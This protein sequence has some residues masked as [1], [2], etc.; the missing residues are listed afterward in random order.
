MKKNILFFTEASTKIGYGHLSRCLSL[1]D[2]LKS[3]YKIFF[4]SEENI[5]RFLPKSIKMIN[6]DNHKNFSFKTVI[7]DL[8]NL[9]KNNFDKIKKFKI[10]NKIIISDHINSKLKSSLTIIPYL[11]IIKA[12]R[13]QKVIN[14]LDALI[15][16]K[17]LISLAKKKGSITKKLHYVIITICFGGSDPKNYTYKIVN[18]IIKLNL[19]LNIKF[20]I[21]IGSL[22]NKESEKKLKDLTYNFKNFEIYRNPKNLYK[23]FNQSNLALINSG[24]I[25]YE[26]A[27]LGVPFFLFAND[28]KS[29]VF[30]RIFKNYFKFF[31]YKDFNFPKK[32]YLK[33][34]LCNLSRKEKKLN[35][36]AKFNKKRINLNSIH[37]VVKHINN[38]II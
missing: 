10:K 38:T 7:I 27:S 8:K 35:F 26:F 11:K 22:Y 9:N 30:C 23:I 34:L 16:S 18:D 5:Q 21:I 19:N 3:R 15:L 13:S 31:Y 20:K 1:S 6:F 32:K 17:K 12:D 25:K 37:N 14:G 29:K 36:Y 33:N 28:K 2:F 24:N 4:I